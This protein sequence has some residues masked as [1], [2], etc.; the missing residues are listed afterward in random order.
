MPRFRRRFLFHPGP[1]TACVLPGCLHIRLRVCIVPVNRLCSDF[2]ALLQEIF[3]I[4]A[5]TAAV[6]QDFRSRMQFVQEAILH[7]SEVYG[8]SAG[9]EFFCVFVVVV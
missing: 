9:D 1:G 2:A 5:G 8:Y 7:N 6:V 3:C 4:A